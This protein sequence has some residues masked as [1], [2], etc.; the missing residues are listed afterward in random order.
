MTEPP[1]YPEPPTRIDS[2][3]LRFEP[4]RPGD[5]AWLAPALARSREHLADSLADL[6]RGLGY[7]LT[8]PADAG[9]FVRQL[10]DDWVARRRFIYAYRE[11]ETGSF[12]G[13]LW[14]ECSDWSVP[15]FEIGYFAVAEHT[16]KG[17]ATEAARTG[18]RIVFDHLGAAKA[19]L[20]CEADNVGSYRVAERCG[21]VLEGRL[22]SEVARGGALIDRLHY[23]M[24][25]EEYEAQDG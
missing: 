15:L 13:D 25:R 4:Y 8:D 22:R 24:L 14:I 12:V 11:R 10:G 23:G 2:D 9:A 3:R 19:R 18:L 1:P 5:G 7:D 21:F 6:R 16:R 20:T 17:Y